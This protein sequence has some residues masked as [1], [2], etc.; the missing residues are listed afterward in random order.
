MRA[1]LAVG[2]FMAA[3]AAAGEPAGKL[4]FD[5]RPSQSDQPRQALRFDV[6]VPRIDYSQPFGAELRRGIAAGI[7]VAPRTAIKLGFSD[8]K[9]VRSSIYP[10]LS[11]DMP[12]SKKK[13]AIS[14]AHRF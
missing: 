2:I 1:L 12:R 5:L 14:V 7:Q 10:D 13:L 9:R 11:I 6:E 8:R 3:P 4:S